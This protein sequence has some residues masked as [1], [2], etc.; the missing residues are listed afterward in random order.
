MINLN[1][2]PGD[3]VATN[4]GV[5]QH[6]SLVTDKYCD[7]EKPMLISATKRNGSVQ[8][9]LWDVVTGGKYTY[10][11]E[12]KHDKT[13]KEVLILARSQIGKWSYSVANN[14]CEHFVKWS[15]GLKISSTQVTNGVGGLAVG[16]AIVGIVSE[17]PTILK[18]LGGALLIAGMAIAV[19]KAVEKRQ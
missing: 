18:F 5:Y 9:E 2:K 14:N 3:V 10:V 12:A 17:K 16:A 7:S 6:W 19:T 11:V 15:T 1:V 8:E 13:I 4:F